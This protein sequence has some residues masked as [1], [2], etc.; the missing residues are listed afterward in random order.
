MDIGTAKPSTAEQEYIQHHLIDVIE[1]N[2]RLSAAKFKQL[3]VSSIE[4]ISERGKV[5]FLVGGSGLYIDSVIYDYDFPPEADV[6][7]RLELESMSDEALRERLIETDEAGFLDT[8]LTNRRRV[9]RALETANVPRLRRD[10]VLPTTIVIGLTMNKEVAQQRIIQRIEK[11]LKEGFIDEVR[12]IG[13]IY[14]PDSEAM[15]I[16]GYR[17]FRDVVF[18]TKSVADGV[19]DFVAGDIALY[20]KQITWFKRNSEIHWLENPADADGLVRNFLAG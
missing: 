18:G 17:A 8:D 9:M 4:Q 1:P 10:T 19:A 3:A 14:G 13:L 20:K 5:P 6:T 7:I 15:N 2:D 11:M 16:I 12:Q